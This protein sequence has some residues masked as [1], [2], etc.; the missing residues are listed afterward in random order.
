MRDFDSKTFKEE[1]EEQTEREMGNGNGGKKVR[2]EK[3]DLWQTKLNVTYIKR[4]ICCE[5]FKNM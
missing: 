3:D 1:E 5:T 2:N 4:H